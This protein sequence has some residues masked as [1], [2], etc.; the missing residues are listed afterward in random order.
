MLTCKCTPQSCFC[1]DSGK[2]EERWLEVY[3]DHDGDDDDHHEDD[4]SRG[5][6]RDKLDVGDENGADDDDADDDDDDDAD[7]AD[8]DDADDDNGKGL[9][10]ED[11]LP[12]QVS[13]GGQ[14]WFCATGSHTSL[15]WISWSSSSLSWSIG[16]PDDLCIDIWIS[17]ISQPS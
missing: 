6:Y 17:V 3:F 10:Q 5:Q 2:K 12:R 13:S 7:D 4:S 1:R 16:H 11:A 8:D 9:M 15:H 14:F